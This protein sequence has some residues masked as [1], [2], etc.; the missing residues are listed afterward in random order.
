[1][2]SESPTVTPP[3]TVE[4]AVPQPRLMSLDALRGFDLFWILGAD[5]VVYALGHLTNVAPVRLLVAQMDH[6]AWAGLTFYDL[7]FP[8]FVFITGV[9]LVFSLSKTLAK[10]GRAA[11]VKHIFSRAALLFALGILY[12]G[13]LSHAWPEVR[14]AGVLQRIALAYAA[15]GLL[16]CFC[17]YRF[18]S[19]VGISLLAIYWALLSFV[20]IRNL[21]LDR[22]TLAAHFGTA[23]PTP[24]QVRQLYENTAVKVTGRF[25]PGLNLANHLDYRFLPGAKY[26]TY[27]DPEGWLSTLPAISTCLI[28][29]MAG[30]CLRRTDRSDRQKLKRLIVTGGLFLTLGYFW[31]TDFPII[32]KIWTSSF[33]LVAGGWSILLLALF[34]Y[35]IEV[36]RWRGWCQPFVWIGLNPI[37][38]YLA[39]ALINFSRIAEHFAGGS[40]AAFFDAHLAPGAGNLLL[41]CV[42]LGLLL[43]LA[44]F[45]HRKQIYLRV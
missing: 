36:R 9:S 5:A 25:E 32:K 17:N 11:A 34:Y 31:G 37:T 40:V 2:N 3:R 44:R 13:G 6:S 8:L 15:A 12:N 38:L 39:T 14:L 29:V 22:A 27:W 4:A 43:T 45:L 21:A 20:P 1:M 7:I 33:V 30:C 24:E 28:G 42:T 26:D 16:F 23:Q 35:L 41:A 18:R 10:H 19:H